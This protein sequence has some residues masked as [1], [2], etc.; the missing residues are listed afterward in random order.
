MTTSG[1][2][3]C[4]LCSEVSNHLDRQHATPSQKTR[5]LVKDMIAHLR[6]NHNHGRELSGDQVHSL[7]LLQCSRCKAVVKNQLGLSQHG[8]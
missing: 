7:G 4:P 2:Q 6:R 1:L 8:S 3:A 5:G